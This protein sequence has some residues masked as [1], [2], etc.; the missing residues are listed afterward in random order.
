MLYTY[1]WKYTNK[2]HV[3]L[4]DELF[5]VYMFTWQPPVSLTHM[6]Q[7]ANTL[8][9]V[10]QDIWRSLIATVHFFLMS[11]M[12][13]IFEDSTT[14]GNSTLRFLTDRIKTYKFVQCCLEALNNSFEKKMCFR[15][16]D[17]K[18]NAVSIW[19][20]GFSSNWSD[21]FLWV[22]KSKISAQKYDT[23]T[24]KISKASIWNGIRSIWQVQ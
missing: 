16:F 7:N 23:H 3:S 19:Q 6:Y 18:L 21:I 1:D 12:Y 10:F 24:F 17:D 9:I 13:C 4:D 22:L 15:L 14:S 20:E 11:I 5:L 2:V 8:Y